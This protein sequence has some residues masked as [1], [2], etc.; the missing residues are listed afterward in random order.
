M[1]RTGPLYDQPMGN[2]IKVAH[3]RAVQ[4][5]GYE[6]PSAT[7]LQHLRPSNYGTRP[8]HIA[9]DCFQGG[10]GTLQGTEVTALSVIAEQVYVYSL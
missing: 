8:G 7:Y 5:L 1:T 6:Q 9:T 3:T 2:L 10:E 4:P